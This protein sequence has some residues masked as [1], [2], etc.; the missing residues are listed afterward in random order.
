MATTSPTMGLTLP[1]V[2]DQT[3]ATI[4]ALA[5]NF[6]KIDAIYP[7]GSIYLSTR[8]T[9]PG[10]FIGGTWSRIQGRFLLGA[11]STYT[12]GSTGGSATHNHGKSPTDNITTAVGVSGSYVIGTGNY[13]KDAST[14][15]PYLAVYMWE[16]TA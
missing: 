12:A 8:S 3:D 9:N 13:V 4:P 11:S 5:A 1:D 7:V 15:P 10:T 2:N 16:R 6:S 14:M